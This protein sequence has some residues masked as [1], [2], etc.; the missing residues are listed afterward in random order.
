MSETEQTGP[1]V[2]GGT[3]TDTLDRELEELLNNE[4]IEEARRNG[5]TLAFAFLMNSINPDYAH[6]IQDKMAVALARYN[7]SSTPPTGGGAAP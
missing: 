2:G 1:G 6:P 5:D 3:G 4:Q 7:G